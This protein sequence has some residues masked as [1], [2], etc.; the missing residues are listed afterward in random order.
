MNEHERLTKTIFYLRTAQS[1]FLSTGA[2]DS[3]AEIGQLLTE[4]EERKRNLKPEQ[5]EKEK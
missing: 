3:Y 2:T 5:P 1:A 4:L